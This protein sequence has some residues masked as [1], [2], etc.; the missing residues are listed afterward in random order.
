MVG[1]NFILKYLMVFDN[2]T[3]GITSKSVWTWSDEQ[4]QDQKVVGLNVWEMNK[5]NKWGRIYVKVPKLINDLPI[6]IIMHNN[7]NNADLWV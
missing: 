6:I 4:L 2:D 5:K 1:V 7:H 3:W